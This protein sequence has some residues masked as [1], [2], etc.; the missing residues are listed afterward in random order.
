MQPLCYMH[1]LEVIY[2]KVKTQEY[3]VRLS[4]HS[5]L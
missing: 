5:F 4:S 3:G 2:E 1:S